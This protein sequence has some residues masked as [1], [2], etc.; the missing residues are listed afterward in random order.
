MMSETKKI[1]I[2]LSGCGVFD[3]AEIHE[4]ILTILA[5]A[6]AGAQYEIFAPNIPQAHVV[7]HLTGE[8]TDENRNVL[9]ESARIA[10]GKIKDLKDYTPA[11]FDAL[12]FP[13]GFGVAKNL[14]N[15]AFYGS[16][17]TVNADVERAVKTTVDAGKPIGA[18]CISPVVIAKILGDAEVTIGQDL[19]TAEAIKKMGGKHIPSSHGDVV[20]DPRY[21]LVTSPCYMLDATIDQIY[22]GAKN[23]VETILSLIG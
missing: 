1:A 20:V 21:K 23:V 14:S 22:D 12:I 3:G 11:G 7:N 15:F 19:D 5:V 16:N 18:L 8:A 2:V 9:V 17:C 4:A 6:R 10:R 13:G